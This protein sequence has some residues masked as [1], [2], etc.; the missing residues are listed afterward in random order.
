MT[1]RPGATVLLAVFCKVPVAHRRLSSE[2]RTVTD[3]AFCRTQIATIERRL[4]R[5]STGSLLASG[6]MKTRIFRAALA[7]LLIAGSLAGCDVQ[8]YDDAVAAAGG[9]PPPPPPP[10]PG[11][12]GP[13]FSEIQA[14]VFTPT[15][16]TANCHAGAN[17][18]GGLNLEAANSYAML[19]QMPSTANAGIMRV[20]P[21]SAANSYL[22]Q[23]L[24]GNG[25]AVMPPPPGA[26]LPQADIDVIR[27]WITNNVP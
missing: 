13:N 22:I 11:G 9:P 2:L 20:E 8:T 24:E 23:K 3:V 16:A 19:Y 7:C 26:P 5:K 27:L 21:L 25:V 17:P 6:I 1:C 18:R 10:P 4:F 14:A 15:C 12:F